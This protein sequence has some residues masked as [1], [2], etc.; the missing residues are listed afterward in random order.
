MISKVSWDIG[1]LRIFVFFII[2]P[3]NLSLNASLNSF[4]QIMHVLTDHFNSVFWDREIKCPR[5]VETYFCDNMHL[6]YYIE[7]NP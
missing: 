2:Q 6:K 4:V 7:V 3:T 5:F 1:D